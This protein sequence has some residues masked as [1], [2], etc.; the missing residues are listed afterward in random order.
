MKW[1][2]SDYFAGESVTESHFMY[3]HKVNNDPGDKEGWA[4]T[5]QIVRIII[6]IWL[7]SNMRKTVTVNSSRSNRKLMN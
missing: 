6:E 4:S 3:R 2:D 7:Q 1:T 5:R